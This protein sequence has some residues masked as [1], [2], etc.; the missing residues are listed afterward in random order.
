MKYV[1]SIPPYIS[2]PWSNVSL[3][4]SQ[5]DGNE[6]SLVIHLIDQDKKVIIPGLSNQKIEA[7]FREHEEFLSNEANCPQNSS[8]DE[9]KLDQMIN[10]SLKA[11]GEGGDPMMFSIQHNPAQKNLPSIPSQLLQKI[12]TAGQMFGIDKSDLPNNPEPHC[13][14]FH[15]QVARVVNGDSGEKE[16][17]SD[18]DEVVSDDDLKFRLWDIQQ[19]GDELY[20]VSNPTN[21]KEVYKVFLG[22]PICCTC[23]KQNCEHIKAVLNS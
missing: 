16:E 18:D 22:T 9:N 14:C 17:L 2:T 12:V 23:G 20:Y 10:V 5:V 7:I 1:L 6:A 4:T 21:D 13:N 3:I 15:C 8:M 11:L 19:E